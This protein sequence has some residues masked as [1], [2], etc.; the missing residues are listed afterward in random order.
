MT[1]VLEN[2]GVAC[3]KCMKYIA[4]NRKENN[5]DSKHNND[6]YCQCGGLEDE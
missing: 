2:S 3:S 6:N 4:F 1:T 5:F